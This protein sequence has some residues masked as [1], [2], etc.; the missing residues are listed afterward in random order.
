MASESSE[1][2]NLSEYTISNMPTGMPTSLNDLQ[3]KIDD[4]F[5]YLKYYKYF[6]YNFYLFNM[7]FVCLYI[8]MII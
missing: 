3:Q 4:W 2:I 6:V 8:V 1:G 7:T 5:V